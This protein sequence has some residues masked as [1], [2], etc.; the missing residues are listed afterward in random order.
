M[1]WTAG[2]TD[3]RIRYAAAFS[4]ADGPQRIDVPLG[5]VGAR[6]D[7]RVRDLWTHTD[8]PHDGRVLHLDLPAHGAALSGG[9][10]ETSYAHRGQDDAVCAVRRSVRVRV[11]G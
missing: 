2:D 3:G 7:D 5:S 11:R 4:L 6:P 9:P 1:L 10:L 8:L